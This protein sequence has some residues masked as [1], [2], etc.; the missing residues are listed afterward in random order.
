MT[1]WVPR[2]SETMMSCNDVVGDVMIQKSKFSSLY[3]SPPSVLRHVCG[4]VLR[5]AD[6]STRAGCS[7][8]WSG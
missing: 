4:E 2:A 3:H 7:T 5:E 8:W 1:T 6:T